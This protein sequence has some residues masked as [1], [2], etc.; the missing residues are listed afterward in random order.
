MGLFN[1]YS[2]LLGKKEVKA[3]KKEAVIEPKAEQAVKNQE[4]A[5]KPASSS[6]IKAPFNLTLSLLKLG[7]MIK[8]DLKLC[9]GRRKNCLIKP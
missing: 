8:K 4:R 6:K 1:Q 2:D 9:S 7:T 5:A 3:A